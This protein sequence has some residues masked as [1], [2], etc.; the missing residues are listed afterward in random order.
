MLS[1]WN[2]TDPERV[3][4]SESSLRRGPM[5]AL[6]NYHVVAEPMRGLNINFLPSAE[7]VK[8]TGLKSIS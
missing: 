7:S 4:V 6:G 1:I 2:K 8:K 5:R 3:R